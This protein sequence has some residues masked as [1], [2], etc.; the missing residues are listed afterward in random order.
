MI[1]AFARTVSGAGLTVAV[2]RSRGPDANA[3]CGQLKGRTEDVRKNR[4]STVHSRQ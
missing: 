1:E 4:Q 3:A 2:R